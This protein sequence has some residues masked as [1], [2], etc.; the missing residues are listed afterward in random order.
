M[1]E[2]E[3]MATAEH[4]LERYLDPVSEALSQQ[5]AQRIV[6]LEPEADVVRRIEQRVDDE[7]IISWDV[8]WTINTFR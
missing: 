4:F 2:L 8:G 3:A 1:V 5:A 6:D 7:V